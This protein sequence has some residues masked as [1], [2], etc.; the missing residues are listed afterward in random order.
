MTD[1]QVPAV[2]LT[3]GAVLDAAFDK[4]GL[5][6]FGDEGFFEPLQA[7]LQSVDQEA[8]LSPLGRYGQF[9]RIV[10]LLVN[11]LRIEDWLAR[12]PEFRPDL[13]D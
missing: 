2:T 13:V 10:E 9:T 12:H 3:I 8:N 5:R 11:R 7:L 6:E 4:A 1:P